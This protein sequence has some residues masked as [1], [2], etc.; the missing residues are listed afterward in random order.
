MQKLSINA[1]APK[2]QSVADA[3]DEDDANSEDEDA[4]QTSTR[5]STHASKP[6]DS[7]PSAPPPTPMSPGFS[8]VPDFENSVFPSPN[9]SSRQSRGSI[10]EKRG[11]KTTQAAS[12][13]IAAGIGIK[14]PKRSEE[15]K[16]YDKAMRENE[17]KRINQQKEEKKRQEEE[18][19]RARA[20]IWD[21]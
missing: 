4:N 16:Q 15:Q 12:R 5:Q 1:S 14:A 7:Y 10:S 2:K 8:N 3:W 17:A 18:R 21:A 6:S 11:E 13:M 19:E 20:A 9:D